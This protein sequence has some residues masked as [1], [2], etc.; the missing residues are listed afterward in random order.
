MLSVPCGIRSLALNMTMILDTGC[1][2]GSCLRIW[3][4]LEVLNLESNLLPCLPKQQGSCGHQST[5]NL[6]MRHKNN[7]TIVLPV[8]ETD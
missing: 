3:S 5:G 6:E 4:G 1:L 2:R 8:A 7:N